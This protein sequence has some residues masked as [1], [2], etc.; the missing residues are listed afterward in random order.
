MSVSDRSNGHCDSDI[1]RKYNE[2]FYLIWLDA[3]Q[4]AQETHNTEQKLR[5]IIN[6][7]QKFHDVQSCKRYIEQKL[8]ND[9]VVL[10]VSGTL[11][12]QIVPCIHK[13]RQV[14]SIYVYCMNKKANECWASKHAKVAF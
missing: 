6:Q 9:R 2:C 7:F 10:I 12:Q 1:T 3:N 5:S 11:G 14:V 13:L 4:N 8:K